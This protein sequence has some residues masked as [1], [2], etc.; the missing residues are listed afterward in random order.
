MKNKSLHKNKIDGQS[1]PY[2]L[3]NKTINKN[4]KPDMNL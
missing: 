2:L 3:K 4:S 1:N